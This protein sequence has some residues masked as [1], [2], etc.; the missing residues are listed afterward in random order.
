MPGMQNEM[1]IQKRLKKHS[2]NIISI[3]VNMPNPTEEIF[4]RE[5][6]KNGWTVSKR[7]WPDFIITKNGE[8]AF[9]EVKTDNR[10]LKKSQRFILELLAKHGLECYLFKPS[11]GLIRILPK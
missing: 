8:T 7:G 3:E 11:T 5:A 1:Y 4:R 10:K 6:H 9:V 2:Q